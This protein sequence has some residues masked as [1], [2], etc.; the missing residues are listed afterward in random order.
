MFSHG[1]VASS[2]LVNTAVF[3]IVIDLL[4]MLTVQPAF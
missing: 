3:T 2:W 4:L 1:R